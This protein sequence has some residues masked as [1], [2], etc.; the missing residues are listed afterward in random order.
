MTCRGVGYGRGRRAYCGQRP[1]ETGLSQTREAVGWFG[2]RAE[3]VDVVRKEVAGHAVEP[4][5]Y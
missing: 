1:V 5:R 4:G 3:G 2:G